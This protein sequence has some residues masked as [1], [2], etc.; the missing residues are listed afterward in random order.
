VPTR[1]LQCFPSDFRSQNGD[2]RSAGSI[3]DHNIA[4]LQSPI[5]AVDSNH[6]VLHLSQ[7]VEYGLFVGME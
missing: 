4:M 2:R 3:P 7:G 6:R 1:I 5:K